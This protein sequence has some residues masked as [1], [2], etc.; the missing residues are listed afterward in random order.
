M[1]VALLCSAERHG[2]L[3]RGVYV[4]ELLGHG[5]RHGGSGTWRS[6]RRAGWARRYSFFR[7]WARRVTA[8]NGDPSSLGHF[9]AVHARGSWYD[10]AYVW[11]A[12]SSGSTRWQMTAPRAKGFTMSFAARS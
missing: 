6:I 7:P 12:R 3:A 10:D 8:S 11:S 2:V 9:L 1:A 5:P 4:C